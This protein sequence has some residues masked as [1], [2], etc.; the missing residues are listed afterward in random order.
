MPSALHANLPRSVHASIELG[1]LLLAAGRLDEAEMTVR[2]AVAGAMDA[3][4]PQH[5]QSLVALT[6]L[7]ALSEQRDDG[8]NALAMHQQ[9]LAG[10]ACLGHPMA[11]QCA[12][13]VVALLRE[14]GRADEAA[15]IA[16]EY[17]DRDKLLSHRGA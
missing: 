15:A 4:S 16:D 9:A 1:R 8:E 11:E 2:E 12:K 14:L 7:G 10:F 6:V 5:P 13:R 3:L 17:G